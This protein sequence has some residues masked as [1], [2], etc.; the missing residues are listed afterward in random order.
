MQ[1]V[2]SRSR[3]LSSG[4]GTAGPVR[5]LIESADGRD[6]WGTAGVSD[7]LIDACCQSLVDA[8][9]YKLTKDDVQPRPAGK[10]GRSPRIP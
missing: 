1:L 8:I 6:R 5:V 10:R 7:D 2:Q 4:V 9:E 3:N